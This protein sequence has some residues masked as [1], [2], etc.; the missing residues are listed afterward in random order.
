M[1]LIRGDLRPG[2]SPVYLKTRL[3]PS[4][5]A[6]PTASKYSSKAS[7]LEP[8]G[9]LLGFLLV[10]DAVSIGVGTLEHPLLHLLGHLVLGDFSAAVDGRRMKFDP[11]APMRDGKA[12][13][14]LRAGAKAIRATVRWEPAAQRAVITAGGKTAAI[15]K[16]QGIIVNG[17]LLMLLRLWANADSPQEAHHSPLLTK[18]F[19]ACSRRKR[20]KC[21]V[22]LN[23]EPVFA[24]LHNVGPGHG[25]SHTAAPIVARRR[26][27]P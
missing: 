3:S 14:P 19:C 27:V 15:G 4:L 18:L 21:E 17:R 12:N 16:S 5:R 24:K 8:L 20:I 9:H 23:N 7:A 22:H 11:P 26:N 13:V 25:D 2:L 10:D 1:R 6:T